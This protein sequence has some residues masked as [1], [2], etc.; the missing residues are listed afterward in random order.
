MHGNKHMHIHG[1][2]QKIMASQRYMALTRNL[3]RGISC[4]KR[5]MLPNELLTN[6]NVQL[7]IRSDPNMNCAM[8]SDEICFHVNQLKQQQQLIVVQPINKSQWETSMTGFCK[9]MQRKQS[10][11]KFRKR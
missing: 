6:L 1:Y 2:F 3:G 4:L 5:F 7:L 8:N 9:G 11:T 10:T